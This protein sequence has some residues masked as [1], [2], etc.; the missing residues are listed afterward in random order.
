MISSADNRALLL[1]PFTPADEDLPSKL[2]RVDYTRGSDGW[3]PASRNDGQSKVRGYARPDRVMVINI[4]FT[5]MRGSGF[6]HDSLAT[7]ASGDSS[8]A[9]LLK[10]L[11]SSRHAPRQVK[12]KFDTSSEPDSMT[13]FRDRVVPVCGYVLEGLFSARGD[14]M[15]AIR[16]IKLSRA[17]YYGEREYRTPVALQERVLRDSLLFG[18]RLKHNMHLRSVAIGTN[19]AARRAQ[20]TIDTS[21]DARIASPPE[22][23][24]LYQDYSGKASVDVNALLSRTKSPLATTE[25]PTHDTQPSGKYSFHCLSPELMLGLNGESTIYTKN[26]GPLQAGLDVQVHPSQLAETSYHR[27]STFDV[28]DVSSHSAVWTL[29]F[30]MDPLSVRLPPEVVD[31]IQCS[32]DSKGVAPSASLPTV[33]DSL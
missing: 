8:T 1:P 9:T 16:L 29:P 13:P 4:P 26:S 19:L 14:E 23:L 27:G 28:P 30:D 22:L 12:R 33:L 32:E 3:Q 21:S 25:L 24:R 31:A 2:F 5:S 20:K 15:V 6:A 7:F 17:P 10:L 11:V 18:R